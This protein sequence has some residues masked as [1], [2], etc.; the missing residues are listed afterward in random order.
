MLR[1]R[2]R[3]IVDLGVNGMSASAHA[4][5]VVDSRLALGIGM[6]GVV[7]WAARHQRNVEIPVVSAGGATHSLPDKSSGES[8]RPSGASPVPVGR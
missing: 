5:R 6:F 3:E 2:S 8:R 1:A 7:E 4:G